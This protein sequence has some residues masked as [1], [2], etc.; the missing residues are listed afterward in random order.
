MRS[1]TRSIT[2]GGAGGGVTID[3]TQTLTNKRITKRVTTAADATSIT[4]NTDNADVTYQANTQAAGTLT[5]NA[6]GGTPT[7]GQSWLLKIKSTNVQTFSW[8][9]VYVGGTVPLP[10][11]TTGSSTIDNFAFLYDTVNSKWQFTGAA[12]G[13]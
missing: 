12:T 9:A 13:Y 5:I 3:G 2:G 11:T 10:T 6:D 1:V 8:N 4:P 7:N